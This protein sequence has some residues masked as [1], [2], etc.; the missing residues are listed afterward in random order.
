[1]SEGMANMILLVEDNPDD[2]ALTMRALKKNNIKNEVMV[3]RD[4]VEALDFLFGT[5]DDRTCCCL[6]HTSAR[7]EKDVK[8]PACLMFRFLP[9]GTESLAVVEEAIPTLVSEPD[10]RRGT[11][12]RHLFSPQQQAH[13]EPASKGRES[14]RPRQTSQSRPVYKRSC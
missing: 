12:M 3:A 8:A 10:S 14:G 11:I 7:G 6:R 9:A 13:S 1:M 2:E 4:G 5:D